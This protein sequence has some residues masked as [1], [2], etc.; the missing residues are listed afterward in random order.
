[1]SNPAIIPIQP[2][3]T[4]IPAEGNPNLPPVLSALPPSPIAAQPSPTNRSLFGRNIST[5]GVTPGA[6]VFRFARP[7]TPQ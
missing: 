3:V 4:G 1:M 5:E 7:E 6:R 2:T